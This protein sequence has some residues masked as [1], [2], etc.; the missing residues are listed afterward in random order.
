[1]PV[2]NKKKEKTVPKKRNVSIAHKKYSITIP[3]SY[4]YVY[5]KLRENL[6]KRNAYSFMQTSEVLEVLKMTLKI[7]RKMKYLVLA[8]METYGILKRINH[9]KYYISD[10]KEHVKLLSK[11]EQCLDDYPFW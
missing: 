2:K 1:M 10:K 9:Q 3:I 8:E 5:Y 7:P 11:V 6:K 4:L